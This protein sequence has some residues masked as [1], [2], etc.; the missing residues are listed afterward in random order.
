MQSPPFSRYL[1]PPKTIG[2]YFYILV[3]GDVCELGVE[4]EGTEMAT[5]GLNIAGKLR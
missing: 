1:V 4:G 2:L 5:D 3:A